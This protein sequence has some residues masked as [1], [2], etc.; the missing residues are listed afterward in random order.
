MRIL[1]TR[2]TIIDGTGA[3]PSTDSCIEIEDHR[4]V[5]VHDRP[6]VTYDRSDLVIDAG[7]AVVMPGIIN[8]HAHGCTRGP[9]MISG[10]PPLSDARVDS[11]LALHLAGGTTTLLNVDGFPEL[12]DAVA[13]NKRQPINVKLASLHTPAHLE[14]ATQGPFPMGGVADRHRTTVD[15][16][17][18]GGAVAIGEAGPGI[19]HHWA[20]HTLIPLAVEQHFGVRI[21]LDTAREL[22]QTGDDTAKAVDLLTLQIG[23]RPGI[24][25]AWDDTCERVR[26]WASF[27]ERALDEAI[28]AAERTKSPLVF[29]HTPTTF[30][31]LIDVTER[32][33]DQVIAAHS[34]FQC[35]T[36]EDTVSRA[37]QL[38][39]AGAWI[40]VMGGDSFGV[41]MFQPTP[42]H[43]F[44]L[45]AEGLCDAISTDY[46]GGFWD[47]LLRVAVEA[48]KSGIVT[49]ER[50]I[51]LLTGNPAIMF[52]ALAPDR[53]VLAAGKI[54]DV[55]VTHVQDPAMVRAVL[56]SGRPVVVPDAP[57]LGRGASSQ[58]KC[59]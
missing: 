40:D 18:A 24:R 2:A 48:W 13:V 51:Q 6:A 44:A 50:A 14:W 22:R 41:R 43:T 35:T 38:K 47:S 34:N 42:A 28:D 54:A 49:L 17:L 5:A 36:V 52:P 21:T 56:V 4:I 46:C 30:D 45:I 19:D 31:R 57:I 10:E 20:D 25:D 59:C 16:M 27:A 8:H 15:D 39:A 55:V 7:G 23:N 53:G 37:R 33:G 58:L 1:I 3:A 26:G 12:E 9:L 11:N 32:L 29:H